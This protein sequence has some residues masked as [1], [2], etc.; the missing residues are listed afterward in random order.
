MAILGGALI[1]PLQGALIDQVGVNLS[2]LLPLFCFIV[3][4]I[5]AFYNKSLK[6]QMK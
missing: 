2:Y 6:R 4:G 1:T 3:I 5:Y